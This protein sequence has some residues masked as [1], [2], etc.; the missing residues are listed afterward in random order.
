MPAVLDIMKF[1]TSVVPEN[2]QANAYFV[3]QLLASPS[4][5]AYKDHLS[6]NWRHVVFP[7]LYFAMTFVFTDLIMSRARSLKYIYSVTDS[8]RNYDIQLDRVGFGTST[9]N[10]L[11][12]K[13]VRRL[14]A[15]A[16]AGVFT[17]LAMNSTTST[18]DVSFV[19]WS[20]CLAWWCLRVYQ[21]RWA[22]TAE[23]CAVKM[24][25]CC[26][27]VLLPLAVRTD[28][29]TGQF[30]SWNS[31]FIVAFLGWLVVA[32]CVSG[33]LAHDAMCIAEREAAAAE[34]E[35]HASGVGGEA[36]DLPSP[37]TPRP[38]SM[39]SKKHA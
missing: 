4:V 6:N 3:E 22:N 38:N 1:D 32:E 24:L 31:I 21:H 9:C 28:T 10:S 12:L 39:N 16:F 5:S 27:S 37:R 35:E 34:A 14:C 13:N 23:A 33:K 11:S 20:Y 7:L 2:D 15:A 29:V 8:R 19:V 17:H 26:S 36:Y 30:C 18:C 25:G